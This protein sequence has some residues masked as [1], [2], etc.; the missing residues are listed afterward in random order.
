MRSRVFVVVSVAAFAA[1]LTL[2]LYALSGQAQEAQQPPATSVE[3][4]LMPLTGKTVAILA[5]DEYEDLE[6]LYP[7]LRF[8][9]AGAAVMIVGR[10][11]CAD[12]VESKHGYACSVTHRANDVS[13]AQVDAV[14]CPGG[15]AP[16]ELRRDEAILA[17][18]RGVWEKGGIVA[19][20]CHG[21]W[22]P[23]SAKIVKGRTMTAYRPVK[24][25]IENAG[26]TFVNQEVVVDGNL[27]SSRWPED[28]PA[29]CRAI[30][31]ALLQQGEQG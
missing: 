9:E 1:L 15:W 13:A 7:A 5:A 17:L 20:I 27:I 12:E 14:I 29:F 11:A 25:D 3:V 2:G 21:A 24:D 8:Q 4:N 16:D 6:L 26:A 18:V 22:V 19:S 10:P 23:I 30:I 28:L 31:T